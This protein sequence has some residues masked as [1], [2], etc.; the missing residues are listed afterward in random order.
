[1]SIKPSRGPKVVRVVGAA[2]VSHGQV[3]ICRRKSGEFAGHWEFPGGKIEH[4]ESPEVALIREI[5][6]ELGVQIEVLGH[7][8]EGS[9]SSPEIEIQLSVYRA[10]L[11]GPKPITS[12]DHD[13]IRWVVPD[14]L[15]GYDFVPADLPAVRQIRR[16][17]LVDP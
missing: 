2:I 7:L 3:L 11:S 17:P 16:F 14:E 8:S 4:T 12:S 6:E 5:Q 10:A 13:Q 15:K 9:Y 1:M